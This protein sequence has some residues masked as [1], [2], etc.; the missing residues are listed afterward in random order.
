[1]DW[2]ARKLTV[3]LIVGMVPI[4]GCPDSATK[5]R[6]PEPT[7]KGLDPV[8][9]VMEMMRALG[10]GDCKTF[11]SL[12]DPAELDHGDRFIEDCERVVE[13]QLWGLNKRHDLRSQEWI[14]KLKE[15]D[16]DRATAQVWVKGLPQQ[17][18]AT[19]H[20]RHLDGAWRVQRFFKPGL[21]KGKLPVNLPAP[22]P[23]SEAA[24]GIA[25]DMV[26]I[27]GGGIVIGCTDPKSGS[28]CIE[29]YEVAVKTFHMD[30]HEVTAAE[31]GRCVVAGACVE[32]MFVPFSKRKICNQGAPGKENHPMN[33]V[34]YFGSEAFCHFV[35][36]RLPTDAEWELAARGTEGRRYPWGNDEVDCTRAAMQ[37]C[38]P[39]GT[40]PV[41]SMA[42]GASPGGVVDLAGNVAEW[43][44]SADES[45]ALVRGGA[46]SGP[47]SYLES[48]HI[49]GMGRVIRI[50]EVG[51]RCVK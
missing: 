28:R 7:E 4:A 44:M 31:Y 20:L 5:S 17:V 34:S 37:G 9:T 3:L 47:R 40:R 14:V 50:P 32:P 46:F 24:K 15:R 8:A 6:A 12:V 38:E 27:E 43:T 49:E 21:E 33:C 26:L 22:P 23:R 10:H 41:G 1:M 42:E 13:T 18:V 2:V 35:G 11:H 16:G 48:V 29:P 19:F 36:K 45:D 51:L 25:D 39:Q 30:R